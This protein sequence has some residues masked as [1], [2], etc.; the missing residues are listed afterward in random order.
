MTDNTEP[1]DFVAA[2]EKL[3]R[4]FLPKLARPPIALDVAEAVAALD[5]LNE[6]LQLRQAVDRAA[7]RS[8]REIRRDALAEV[9]ETGDDDR[10][11]HVE[12][13]AR[14]ATARADWKTLLGHE[15]DGANVAANFASIALFCGRV[16]KS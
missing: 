4:D 11:S 14:T 12:F 1:F 10:S 13:Y 8:I 7:R 16:R 2:L 3:N 9:P 5:E 6:A 15:E